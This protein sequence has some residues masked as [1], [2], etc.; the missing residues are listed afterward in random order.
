[1]TQEK[2]SPMYLDGN[3]QWKV[4]AQCEA[5]EGI[6]KLSRIFCQH[7]KA[8]QK[9][10]ETVVECWFNPLEE[11]P[12]FCASN[13]DAIN[14]IFNYIAL[15]K[16]A[17]YHSRKE[18]LEIST[19]CVEEG[20]KVERRIMIANGWVKLAND[21]TLP[22]SLYDSLIF[23]TTIE[24]VGKFLTDKGLTDR[25][26]SAVSGTIARLGWEN[27]C[28]Q[29]VDEEDFRRVELEVKDER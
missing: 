11:T 18:T 25:E 24:E 10:N 6:E 26:K 17:G 15:I 23:P 3:G 12:A 19:R 14:D 5:R 1:M 22:S 13:V 21:Q 7:C 20:R 9:S 27:C 8:M 28:H 4:K 2:E 29:L 16:E